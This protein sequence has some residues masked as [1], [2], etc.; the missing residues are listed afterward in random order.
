[1]KYVS[2]INSQKFNENFVIGSGIPTSIKLL[3]EISFGFFNLDFSKYVEVNEN[4][5][6]KNDPVTRV[7]NIE[8]LN[9]FFKSQKFI[10][11]EDVIERVIKYKIYLRIKFFLTQSAKY[12]CSILNLVEILFF[13]FKNIK[14][15]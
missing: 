1:M 4:L 7:A 13:I 14:L 6:R 11:I 2:S 15:L 8:K 10:P 5:L 3:V 12:F 9:T